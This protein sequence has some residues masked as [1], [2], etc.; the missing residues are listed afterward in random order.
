MRGSKTKK[1]RGGLPF[2]KRKTERKVLIILK[3]AKIT[4]IVR[5]YFF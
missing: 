2:D 4:I 1:M 5:F 3:K